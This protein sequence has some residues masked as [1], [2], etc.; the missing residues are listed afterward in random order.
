[1]GLRLRVILVLTI[2]AVLLLGTH[3]YLRVREEREQLFAEHRQNMGLTATV[4]QIAVENALRDRQVSDVHR[5]VGEMVARQEPIDR[6]RL[7]DLEGRSVLVAGTLPTPSATP[8]AVLRRVMDTATAESFYDLGSSPPRLLYLVPIRGG[9]GRVEAV[10]EIVHVATGIR[11]RVTA[12]ITD[13]WLRLSIIL[14]ALVL[15]TWFALRR[16]VLRPLARLTEGIQRLGRGEQE[17]R[18]AVS[19]RD[20][21]GR[22]AEAFNQMSRDLERARVNL[23]AETERALGFEQELRR[24]ET[25]A[26]AGKLTSALAHEVGT[27]LNV[28]SGRAEFLAKSLPLETPGRKD[29]EIIV[30]QIDRITR[31]ISSVLDTVRPHKPEIRATAI[32]EILDGVVP[33]LQHAAGR[34]QVTLTAHVERD[35]PHV[36]TDPGQLQQVLI[37]L[38]LNAVDATPAGGR[39]DVAARPAAQDGREGM[40]IAVKDTGVGIPPDALPR[41]FEPFYSTKGAGRGSGLGLAICRDILLAHDGD[42]RAESELGAGSTFTVWLPAG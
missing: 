8:T 10:M 20:E 15:L 29:L 38:V 5:L 32:A 19:R 1:M 17:T 2:P 42:I 3:G 28:I 25:L 31:I 39:V 36:L 7:F 9:S 40:T 16:Q 41:I 27:P 37:N 22:V 21:L 14:V 11:R 13:V 30:A 35:V 23:L 6:I 33:L 18:L 12:A 4:V 26:V 34:R 24:A